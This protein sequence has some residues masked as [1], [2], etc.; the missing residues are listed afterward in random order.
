LGNYEHND[1][2]KPTKEH[3]VPAAQISEE[4]AKHEKDNRARD[5]TLDAPN[6]TYD[7]DE[8]DEHRPVIDAKSRFRRDSELLQKKSV[9]LRCQSP[10]LSSSV[11]FL[12]LITSISRVKTNSNGR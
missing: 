9:H 10:P 1:D 4:F 5:R 12:I 11:L 3:Q 8:N 7:N 6:T 2:R